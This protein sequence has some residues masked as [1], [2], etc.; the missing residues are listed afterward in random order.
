MKL[1]NIKLGQTL[2]VTRIPEY[3]LSKDGISKVLC[4][5]SY[6]LSQISESIGKT[7]TVCAMWSYHDDLPT[8]IYTICA[9]IFL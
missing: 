9:N 8:S 4:S 6:D 1:N 3:V 7:G 2:T 5:I